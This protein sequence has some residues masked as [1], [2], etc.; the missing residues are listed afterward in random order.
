M[1]KDHLCDMDVNIAMLAI[2]HTGIRPEQG[3]PLFRCSLHKHDVLCR[4]DCLDLTSCPKSKNSQKCAV[5]STPLHYD[6]DDIQGIM[7]AKGSRNSLNLMWFDMTACLFICKST[8]G[9]PQTGEPRCLLSCTACTGEREREREMFYLTTHSTHLI[10]G[11][12]A[13]DIW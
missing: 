3:S 9:L 2:W 5:I 4:N 11:Y 13:S 7:K 8:R 12:M 6:C 10:Y 1:S